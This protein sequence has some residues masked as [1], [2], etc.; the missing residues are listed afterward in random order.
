MQGC[1]QAV[2]HTAVSIR[3][4]YFSG[5]SSC[6]FFL[7]LHFQKKK[8][9]YLKSLKQNFS[10]LEWPW[11]GVMCCVDTISSR[12]CH[13]AIKSTSLKDKSM[14]KKFQVKYLGMDFWFVC[15]E[16]VFA[17][18]YLS[19]L[20][21]VKWG[22]VGRGWVTERTAV[23]TAAGVTLQVNEHFNATDREHHPLL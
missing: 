16:E 22:L 10:P 13:A 11:S 4:A 20:C 21:R 2:T 9:F 1:F 6:L 5:L 15:W 17:Y 3:L 14:K 23:M 7:L 19:G 18:G 8:V 12:S